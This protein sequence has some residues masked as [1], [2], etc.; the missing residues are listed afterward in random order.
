MTCIA[1]WVHDTHVYLG[2]DTCVS[3]GYSIDS[4]PG[5]LFAHGDMILGVCGY[6]RYADILQYVWTPPTHHSDVPPEKWMVAELVPSV[7]TVVREQGYVS[8]KDGRDD[9]IGGEA[10][11]GY[12]GSLWRLCVD[13]AVMRIEAQYAASGSGE[14]EAV[15]ALATSARYAPDLTPH[16][17]LHHALEVSSRYAYGVRG[18][19]HIIRTGEAD[20]SPLVPTTT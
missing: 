8:T 17:H 7:R 13:G 19:Y 20:A 4:T 3:R 6:G 12:R 11:I 1:G 14:S 18:P 5:K 10:L 2:A 15:A 16:Q 9:H